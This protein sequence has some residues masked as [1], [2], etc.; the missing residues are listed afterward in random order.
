MINIIASSQDKEGAKISLMKKT[1]G[2]EIK[3]GAFTQKPDGDLQ[4]EW[5]SSREYAATQFDHMR[6]PG[7]SISA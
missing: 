6:A 1:V 3:F 7:A 2:R 5:S 4:G